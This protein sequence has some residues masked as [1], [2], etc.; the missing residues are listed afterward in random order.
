MILFLVAA[1]C[2]L[3]YAYSTWTFSYWRKKK[4]KGPPPIPLFGNIKDIVLFKSFPGECHQKIYRQYPEERYVGI[5]Q[6]R[7]PT[8]LLRDPDLIKHVFVKD[9]EHF[10][11]R[12][13]HTNE[14]REPLTAHLVSLE[15]SRWRNLRAKLTPAFSS[16][17]IKN[18][19]PLMSQCSDNLVSFIKD[20]LKGD[21]GDLEVREVTARFTTDVIG[22]VAFGLQFDAMSGDSVFREM[23]K[24][25]TQPTL[26]NAMGRATRAFFPW[27]FDALQMRTFP[28]EIHT[29]FTKFV[30]ETI[31][32]RQAS[33]E[34]RAD[35]LQLMI[36]LK[37]MDATLS[38]AEDSLV[39][40][41]SVIAAQAFVFFLAGFETSATTLSFCLYELALNPSCQE[42]AFREISTVRAKHETL[43]YE[44]VNEMTYLE[45]LLEETMRKHPPVANLSRVCNKAYAIPGSDLTIDPG[46][47]I[48][49]PVHALHHDPINFPDPERFIPERFSNKDRLKN[50]SYLPFGEG[51]RHC[52]GMRFAMLEM[53][54][55][56]S[57]ILWHYKVT[58][59]PK[60]AIP[61]KIDPKT[62]ITTPVGGVW[63]NLS[64]RN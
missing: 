10:V 20:Q 16:G 62:F 31:D 57:Q 59:C 18:M 60:T 3:F 56:L 11:D 44:A 43:S 12:G 64:L 52:I 29:F 25:I 49:V 42:Q 24:K 47:A 30:K 48:V 55:A 53:K 26:S 45:L 54:L 7:T 19:F 36:Q 41:D 38:Q 28:L 5:Y 37:N 63:V 27:L 6:L 58:Q 39:F 15:G 14:E 61:L 2:F 1:L 4:V 40:T 35:F 32:Y 51:P 33:G 8:L 13:F 46:V 22:T 34:K 23:G 50:H 21:K 9:F 17:K